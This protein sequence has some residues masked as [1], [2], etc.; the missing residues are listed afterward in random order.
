MGKPGIVIISLRRE[1]D[2]AIATVTDDGIG[3]PQELQHKVF[4]RF[5]QINTSSANSSGLGLAI[6]KEICDSLN[7]SILL[8]TP[9]CGSGLQVTIQFPILQRAQT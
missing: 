2:F 4:E 6:V 7:A 5:F 3:I 8:S 9:S 1:H